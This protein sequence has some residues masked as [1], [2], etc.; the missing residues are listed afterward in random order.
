MVYEMISDKIVEAKSTSRNASASVSKLDLRMKGK[1]KANDQD[2]YKSGIPIVSINKRILTHLTSSARHLYKLG[3]L[4]SSSTLIV[5]DEETHVLKQFVT[6]KKRTRLRCN[7]KQGMEPLE[8]F[9]TL[10]VDDEETHLYCS[11]YARRGLA[12]GAI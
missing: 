4:S 5:D 1:M 3:L 8:L 7:L 12:C 6:G 2:V 10:I 9:I 11:G